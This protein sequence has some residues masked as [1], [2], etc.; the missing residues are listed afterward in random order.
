MDTAIDLVWQSSYATVGVAEI[1]KQAGVTKGCFYHYFETKADLFY[2]SSQ[3]YWD[4]MKLDLDQIF[5]PSFTPLEQ[6]E[7]LVGYIVKKQEENQ[8][9]DNPVSGCPF[10]TSGVQSG[11]GE[12][13]VRVAAMVMADNA[14][15]YN[16]ALIRA[17]K[18]DGKLEGDVDP[19][20]VGR[21]LLNCVMGLLSYGR[22]YRS[23]DVVKRDL[24]ESIYRVIDLKREFRVSEPQQY[25]D[26]ESENMVS[27]AGA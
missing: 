15:K 4:G 26:N 20:Q 8:H 25:A 16:T 13:K 2:E 5:S 18:A 22:L 7:N 19:E 23:L 10:F 6:L 11:A 9:D 14:V 3:Y 12:E 27:A 1:C 24:R 21:M 17:L